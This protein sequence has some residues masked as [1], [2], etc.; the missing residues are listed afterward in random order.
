MKSRFE[1]QPSKSR[2]KISTG[3][4]YM[5][6]AAFFFS[7]MAATVKAMAHRI[8]SQ[9]LVL[10]RSIILFSI[11]AMMIKKY[12]L[13]FWG[14][15]KPLLFLR[16]FFGFMG[17]SAFFFTLTHIPIADSVVIQYTSPLFTALMAPFILREPGSR[18]Q[19]MIY[20]I[21]FSGI[22]LIVRPGFSLTFVPASIG[23]FGAFSAGIAYNLIRKLRQTEHPLNII[24]YLPAVSIP[25]SIPL[26]VNNFVMPRGMEWIWLTFIGIF[27]FIAQVF[28]TKSLHMEKAALA[29]NA[30]YISIVFSTMWGFI[31][32]NE[33]P[34]LLTLA[35]A[36]IIIIAIYQMAVNR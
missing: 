34:D 7:L 14:R 13:P 15:N 6:L 29:T 10:A 3:L 4:I 26:I 21:A 24:L 11:T 12:H 9:E 36:A 31:F 1:E 5:I 16:G 25:C 18:K 27:T 22:L 20:L 17:L 23:L 28:L 2:K 8:P 19:W 35:G 32:W 30:S 33:I